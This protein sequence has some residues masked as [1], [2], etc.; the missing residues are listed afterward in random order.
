[1]NA[2]LTNFL[3][4]FDK[5]RLRQPLFIQKMPT[6][7]SRS[8]HIYKIY[9]LSMLSALYSEDNKVQYET[10]SDVLACSHGY[11]TLLGVIKLR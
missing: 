11:R 5:K 7:L 1:M 6:R 3:E 9:L 4:L 10:M 8:G 2:D